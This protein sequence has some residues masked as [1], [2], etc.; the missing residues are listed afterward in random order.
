MPFILGGIAAI[1]AGLILAVRRGI[2]EWLSSQTN[3][4]MAK[5]HWFYSQDKALEA[6]ARSVRV[7]RVAL[8]VGTILIGLAFIL[9]GAT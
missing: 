2:T 4:R 1:V 7:L 5:L 3:L 9:Q 6:H 8:P